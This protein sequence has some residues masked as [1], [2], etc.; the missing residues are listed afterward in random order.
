MT[1]FHLIRH[2]HYSLLG[3]VLAGR[4]PGHSLSDQGRAQ[5]AALA[6]MLAEVPIV[7]VHSSPMERTRETAAVIAASLGLE[8]TI[9]DDLNEIDYGDWTATSF[10]A[11]QS[12][13]MWRFYNRFRSTAPIPKGETMLAVQARAFAVVQ[14]LRRTDGHVV[15]VSHADIIKAIL[16]H[17]LGMPLDLSLRLDITPASRSV[18]RIFDEDVRVLGV[19]LPTCLRE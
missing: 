7:A 14:R 12:Q 19:N 16:A 3:R 5:A 6:E 13:P 8:V 9:E 2:A 1:T 10:E 4:T 11:L 17:L 18:V 15:L